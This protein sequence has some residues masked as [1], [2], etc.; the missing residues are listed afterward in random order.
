MVSKQQEGRD[1]APQKTTLVFLPS[2]FEIKQ[3]AIKRVWLVTS[4]PSQR[5]VKIQKG[6]KEILYG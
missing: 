2:L 4:L 5:K 3:K 6:G 1:R